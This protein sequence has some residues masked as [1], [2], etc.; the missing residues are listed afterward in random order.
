MTDTAAPV[1]SSI[2][3]SLLFMFSVTTIGAPDLPLTGKSDPVKVSGCSLSGSGG[4]CTWSVSPSV[5]TLR[6]VFNFC[7]LEG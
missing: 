4:G 5:S 7:W 1:S 3:K 6:T 2:F